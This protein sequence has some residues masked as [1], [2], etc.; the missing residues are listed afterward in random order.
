MAANHNDQNLGFASPDF[1][2]ASDIVEYFLESLSLPLSFR[3]V[4]LP[5]F[6]FYHFVP[7]PST[8]FISSSSVLSEASLFCQRLL[9]IVRGSVLSEVL[10]ASIRLVQK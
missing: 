10:W 8:F 4:A 7:S 9:C 5:W 2:V 1:S 6:Y 3:E